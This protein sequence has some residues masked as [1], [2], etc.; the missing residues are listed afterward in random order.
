[1]KT[2]TDTQP[3]DDGTIDDRRKNSVGDRLYELRLE[4]AQA[5]S[6]VLPSLGVS[7]Y[8]KPFCNALGRRCLDSFGL[9]A[10]PGSH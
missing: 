9:S 10:T 5:G 8:R 6:L 2:L 1:M 7:T 4:Q 3:I